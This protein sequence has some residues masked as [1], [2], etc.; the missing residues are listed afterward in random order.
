MDAEHQN[1]ARM[2]DAELFGLSAHGV[3][4]LGEP[5]LE[6][7]QAADLIDTD[8]GFDVLEQPAL[9]ECL[10]LTSEYGVDVVFVEAV[11]INDGVGDDARSLSAGKGR[12]EVADDCPEPGPGDGDFDGA[13][14]VFR[15]ATCRGRFAPTPA[16]RVA[17]YQTAWRTR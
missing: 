14:A 8:G 9:V 17:R 5:E 16:R 3:L 13:L 2:F 12:A 1:A 6:S 15:V 7:P 4:A 11:I 10:P